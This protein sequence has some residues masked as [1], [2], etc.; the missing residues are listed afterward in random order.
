MNSNTYNRKQ[1]SPNKTNIAPIN[2]QTVQFTSEVSPP[3]KTKFI[4]NCPNIKRYKTTKLFALLQ[5]FNYTT[6]ESQISF[7]AKTILFFNHDNNG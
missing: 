3:D 7:L 5:L 4:C 6:K 2:K 1:T